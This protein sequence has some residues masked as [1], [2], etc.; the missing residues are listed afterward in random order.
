MEKELSTAPRA[1][2]MGDLNCG[3]RV[4]NTNVK[5]EFQCMFE[6]SSW[7][8][9]LKKK[10][11]QEAHGPHRSPEKQVQNNEYM[12]IWAKLL[13]YISYIWPSLEEKSLW[14]ILLNCVS[15]FLQFCYYL[16]LKKSRALHLNKLESP[17]Q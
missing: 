6:L 4:S 17:S 13:L 2:I 3:P 15:V 9:W 14:G 7:N 11:K 10:G 12:Y 8:I 16:P 1:V 5:E